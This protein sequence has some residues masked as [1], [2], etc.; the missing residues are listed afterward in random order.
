MLI[1]TFDSEL[2]G[3]A[4]LEHP[5]RPSR[6]RRARHRARARVL[7]PAASRFSGK[8]INAWLSHESQAAFTRHAGSSPHKIGW[9]AVA[10]LRNPYASTAPGFRPTPSMGPD[11][12]RI[13]AIEFGPERVV[14]RQAVLQRRFRHT[15][16][17][18]R[19]GGRNRSHTRSD[20]IP[21]SA[22]GAVR[23]RTRRSDRSIFPAAGRFPSRRCRA[24]DRLKLRRDGQARAGKGGPEIVAV[25][26]DVEI[27]ECDQVRARRRSL[28]WPSYFIHARRWTMRSSGIRP[29]RRGAIIDVERKPE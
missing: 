14:V 22:C 2:G 23:S 7:K 3:V 1:K 29:H 4:A 17:R 6:T 24:L 19:C 5:G 18:C 21:C 9:P 16:S 25:P 28:G 20:D 27:A 15:A 11:G 8:N 26:V 12:A 13:R 10:G